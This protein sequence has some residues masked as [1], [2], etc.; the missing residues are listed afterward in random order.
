MLKE[1]RAESLR[2]FL[3]NGHYRSQVS[4]SQDNLQSADASVERLYNAIRGLDIAEVHSDHP[5]ITQFKK[6]MDDDFNVPEALAV[7]FELSKEVNRL[8]VYD[9]EAAAK[10]AAVLKHLADVLGLLQQ[11]P[12][13]FLKSGK[14]AAD[15]LSNDDVDAL[16]AARVK[17]RADKDW[18]RADEIRKTLEAAGI[19]LEDAGTETSW[20][21]R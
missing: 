6:A 19:E 4:Y 14:A 10:E 21:R 11:D 13:V 2:Y 20:R 7:L 15:G 5:A 17:A 1:Y 8:R 18:A 16:V 12:E 3:L 9:I